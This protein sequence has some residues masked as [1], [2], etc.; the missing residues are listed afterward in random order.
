MSVGTVKWDVWRSLTVYGVSLAAV[1]VEVVTRL[2]LEPL[3][4]DHLPFISLFLAVG[5]AAWY[6]G[7]G[8]GLLALAVSIVAAA[9]II[10]PPRYSSAIESSAFQVG[11]VV[12]VV[13]ALALIAM[14]EVL[15]K[16]QRLSEDQRRQL[17]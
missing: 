10:L 4:A 14:F 8:P 13:V 12:Y 5:F 3:L 11:L 15:R 2:I 6:G 9:F 7:R 1:A 16:A 17:L